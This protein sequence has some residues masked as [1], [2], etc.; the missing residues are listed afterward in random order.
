MKIAKSA[1]SVPHGFSSNLRTYEI[2][3]LKLEV[4][5]GSWL[6][7]DIT[8]NFPINYEQVHRVIIV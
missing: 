5:H 6:C 7:A 4:F 8:Q 2:L 3:I 1:H